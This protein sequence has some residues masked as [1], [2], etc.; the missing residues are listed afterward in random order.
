MVLL[1]QTYVFKIYN[2]IL[3]ILQGIE[4]KRGPP[5]LT[6]R[7][8]VTHERVVERGPAGKAGRRVYEHTW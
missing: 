5:D 6:P 7:V 3:R 8:H 1:L 2:Q 4:L